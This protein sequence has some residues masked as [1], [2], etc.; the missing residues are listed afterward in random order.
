MIVMILKNDSLI[1]CWLQTLG[2]QKIMKLLEKKSYDQ[3][4][5]NYYY[6]YTDFPFSMSL[7]NEFPHTNPASLDF[8]I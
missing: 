2:N 6:L 8:K 7:H 3:I 5:S 1:F 4:I